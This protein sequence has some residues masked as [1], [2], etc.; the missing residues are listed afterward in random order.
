MLCPSTN[1]TYNNSSPRSQFQVLVLHTHFSLT[2]LTRVILEKLTVALLVTKFPPFIEP[3]SSLPQFR[4]DT[5][6]Q[7]SI[8]ILS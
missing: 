2:Q 1:R 7:Q 5:A 4:I 6:T 3:E 8:L